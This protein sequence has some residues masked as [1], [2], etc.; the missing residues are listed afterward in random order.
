MRRA[1]L[2]SLSSRLFIHQ[3]IELDPAGS[4]FEFFEALHAEALG[5]LGFNHELDHARST[6]QLSS[7]RRGMRAPVISVSI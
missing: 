5:I 1:F 3:M 7:M 6:R 4:K 2:I